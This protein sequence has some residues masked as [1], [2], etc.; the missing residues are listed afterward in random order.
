MTEKL[1]GQ[2]LTEL[3]DLLERE[4][5][6]SQILTARLDLLLA[7]SE[8]AGR[9]LGIV[10]ARAHSQLAS[11]RF[12]AELLASPKELLARESA[13][14]DVAI[15]TWALRPSIPFSGFA[16]TA[17]EGI[18]PV[19]GD[20]DLAPIAARACRIDCGFDQDRRAQIGSGVV[21]SGDGYEWTIVT[22]AHVVADLRAAGWSTGEGVG[23]WASVDSSPTSGGREVVSLKEDMWVHPSQDLALLRASSPLPLPDLPRCNDIDSCHPIA[24][25]GFPFFDSRRD[26]WPKAFGF[27]DPAGVLRLSP[28]VSLEIAT[29]AWRG[30]D[31]QLLVHDAST[32]SG[33]SGS[34][35]F[36]LPSLHLAGIHV[37]GWPLAGEAA[38]RPFA[39]NAAVPIKELEEGIP[40]PT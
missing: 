35:L 40:W 6:G 25:V 4:S 22:A 5:G 31:V 33:S 2:E 16:S 36:T 27:R 10:G 30:S 38:Q 12:A 7:S 39:G 28:G 23:G 3:N 17:E 13:A 8:D 26:P 15:L 9:V 37:G 21:L 1:L 19:L 11:A 29:R 20:L 24:V 32:L 18:W 14:E 34:G